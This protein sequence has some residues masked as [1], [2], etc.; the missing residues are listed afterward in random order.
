MKKK[1]RYRVL[2]HFCSGPWTLHTRFADTFMTFQWSVV[3]LI[4]TTHT[5]LVCD[6]PCFLLFFSCVVHTH[7]HK[8]CRVLGI[9]LLTNVQ[10]LLPCCTT[11]KRLYN[12]LLP[13]SMFL[14]IELMPCWET[15]GL[16]LFIVLCRVL[17]TALPNDIPLTAHCQRLLKGIPLW[18]AGLLLYARKPFFLCVV[19]NNA[20]A[21]YHRCSQFLPFFPRSLFRTVVNFHH[22]CLLY[23]EFGCRNQA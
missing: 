23:Y 18:C 11:E 21:M 17:Y 2:Q 20:K 16:L 12:S 15:N 14:S 1:G 19:L 10:S 3:Y 6:E 4:V 13:Y 7:L 9:P 5:L 22:C 8:L